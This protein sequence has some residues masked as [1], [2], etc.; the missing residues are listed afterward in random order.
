MIVGI[1]LLVS[2]FHRVLSFCM[3]VYIYWLSAQKMK[4]INKKLKSS[5]LLK[6]V[7]FVSGMHLESLSHLSPVARTWM[8]QKWA[9]EV[10]VKTWW[11][12]YLKGATLSR[13][14]PKLRS[15]SQALS[16]GGLG[17]QFLSLGPMMESEL[18]GHILQSEGTL[19]GSDP[20]VLDS[21]PQTSILPGSDLEGLCS[22]TRSVISLRKYHLCFSSCV[23]VEV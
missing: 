15:I 4:W 21:C 6:W 16:L 14:Y 10:P 13:T 20:H 3:S 23:Q 22:L 5:L 11:S 19:R 18:L 17:F 7:M 1:L 2:F 9:C 12:L 8:A